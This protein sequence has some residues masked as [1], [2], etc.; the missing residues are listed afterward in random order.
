MSG[1]STRKLVVVEDGLASNGPHIEQLGALDMRFIL[2]A[3]PG[4]HAFLF[5]WVDKTPATRTAEFAGEDGVRHRFRWLNGA[6][7]ND[8]NF[9]IEVNFIEYREVRPGGRERRFSWVTEQAG[10]RGQSDG[11]DAR[12]A[13]AVAA[14]RRRRGRERDIQHV[15]RTKATPSGTTSATAGSTCRR[16]WRT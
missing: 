5:E 7:L 1:G 4:D 10:R 14:R 11:S 3:K 16:C 6:P 2:G 13:G 15:R 12:R 8:A 9:G